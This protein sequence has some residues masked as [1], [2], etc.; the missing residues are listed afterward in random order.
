M[1]NP[2]TAETGRRILGDAASVMHYVKPK[3]PS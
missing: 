1:L 3:G 2:S